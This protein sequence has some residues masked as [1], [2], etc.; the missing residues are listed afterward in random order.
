[1]CESDIQC[2]KEPDD[3]IEDDCLIRCR[4]LHCREE[5]YDQADCECAVKPA[6]ITGQTEKYS[7][8]KLLFE[9]S[10][11]LREVED[12]LFIGVRNGFSHYPIVASWQA[13]D[14]KSSNVL[15]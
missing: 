8:K 12:E 5:R 13:E 6:D 7:Y 4:I 10:D 9:R 2:S 11:I 3:K 1:M 14:N 15:S